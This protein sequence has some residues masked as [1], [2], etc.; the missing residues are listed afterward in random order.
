MNT[1]IILS[2]IGGATIGALVSFAVTKEKYEK[3]LDEEIE[4]IKEFYNDSLEEANEVIK[5]LANVTEEFDEEDHEIYSDY[6]RP[7]NTMNLNDERLEDIDII[8]VVTFDEMD[9]EFDKITI[10][11]YMDDIYTD[12]EDVV[13]ENINELVGESN[14]TDIESLSAIDGNLY[15]R[16][17]RLMSDYMVI[18]TGTNYGEVILGYEIGGDE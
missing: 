7:Y 6:T 4:A 8:S 10:L 15:V 13:I 18:Q 9:D 17:H 11:A 14:L 2:F 5:D 3:I 12:E 16:N 1:K